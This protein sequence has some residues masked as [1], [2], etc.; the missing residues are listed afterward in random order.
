MVKLIVTIMKKPIPNSSSVSQKGLIIRVIESFHFALTQYLYDTLLHFHKVVW[1]LY[2]AAH[3]M[4]L[5][6]GA[7]PQSVKVLLMYPTGIKE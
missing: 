6:Y 5:L 3:H 2:N 4:S 1:D 7:K